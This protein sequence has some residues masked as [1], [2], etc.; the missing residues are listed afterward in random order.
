[1]IGHS[2]Y[3]SWHLFVTVENKEVNN[4]FAIVAI[5]LNETTYV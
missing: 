3:D 2:R 1:M 4:Q 5:L